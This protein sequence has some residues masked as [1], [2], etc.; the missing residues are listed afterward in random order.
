MSSEILWICTKLDL[1]FSISLNQN[2][3]MQIQVALV[4]V[5]IGMASG[6]DLSALN[7]YLWYPSWLRTEGSKYVTQIT[8]LSA[9]IVAS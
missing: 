2:R 8:S 3:V 7:Q 4:E 6:F 9:L 1:Y 5:K